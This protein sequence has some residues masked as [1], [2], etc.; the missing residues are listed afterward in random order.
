MIMY[1]NQ[2][3]SAVT[4][5]DNT[6]AGIY[7]GVTDFA[8][9][10]DCIASGEIPTGTGQPLPVNWNPDPNNLPWY[11]GNGTQPMAYNPNPWAEIN[12]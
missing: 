7:V 6:P 11:T 3:D 4:P 8:Q 1:V 5:A 12:T 10:L 9:I 2:L